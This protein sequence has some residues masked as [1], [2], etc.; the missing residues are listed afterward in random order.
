MTIRQRIQQISA[1]ISALTMT[2]DSTDR[3]FWQEVLSTTFKHLYK[4]CPRLPAGAYL[5]LIHDR[6]GSEAGYLFER[7]L[8]LFSP[9][10][11]HY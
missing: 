10:A 1:D 9:A 4:Q 6:S 3:Y 7:I 5:F 2:N 11:L 8:P